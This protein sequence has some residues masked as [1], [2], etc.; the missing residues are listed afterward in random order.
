MDDWFLAKLWPLNKR[1]FMVLLL[2]K[3]NVQCH[4]FGNSNFL[5]NLQNLYK[6]IS[7][8]R[9][10]FSRSATLWHLASPCW[11]L[12]YI[13]KLAFGSPWE[14]CFTPGFV[15]TQAHRVPIH[16]L[17]EWSLRD[18]FLVPW[19]RRQLQFHFTYQNFSYVTFTYLL[20]QNYSFVMETSGHIVLCQCDTVRLINYLL[21]K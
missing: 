12:G 21:N 6:V 4:Q 11:S 20:F 16:T 8:G 18:S 7:F 3:N 5:H 14:N 1:F 10:A 13:R 2:Q 17:V 9:A 15:S 19:E